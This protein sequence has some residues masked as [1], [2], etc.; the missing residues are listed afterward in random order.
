MIEE[1]SVLVLMTTRRNVSSRPLRQAV[2]WKILNKL[3]LGIC[4]LLGF[5]PCTYTRINAAIAL[6]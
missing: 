4:L 1:Y 2:E 5:S 6:L 3:A